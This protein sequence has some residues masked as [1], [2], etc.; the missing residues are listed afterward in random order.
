M[1]AGIHTESLNT[2]GKPIVPDTLDGD[3]QDLTVRLQ[4]HCEH[5]LREQPNA[6]FTG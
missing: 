4:D 6:V 3:V 2:I 1:F 5:V